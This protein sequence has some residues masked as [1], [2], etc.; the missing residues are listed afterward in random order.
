MAENKPQSRR[1]TEPANSRRCPHPD[2]DCPSDQQLRHF[3]LGKLSLDEA[4]RIADTIDTC[5]ECEKFVTEFESQST[6]PLLDDMLGSSVDLR[7]Q[8]EAELQHAIQQVAAISPSETTPRME[9][10]EDVVTGVSSKGDI[11]VSMSGELLR[12]RLISSGLLSEEDLRTLLND[13]PRCQA[14]F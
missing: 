7:F 11:G 9:P 5:V 6:D 13:L 12:K 2:V 8:N 14:A 10:R 3:V 4:D 1:T